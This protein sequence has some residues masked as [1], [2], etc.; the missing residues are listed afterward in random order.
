M[1]TSTF[2]RIKT[3]VG[4]V[5]SSLK[6]FDTKAQEGNHFGREGEYT[7]ESLKSDL[8]TILGDIRAL[9]KAHDEFVR[10]SSWEE[11]DT[12]A[13][14]L[15]DIESNLKISNYMGVVN[16]LDA[17]KVSIRS[18]NFRTSTESEEVLKERIEHLD[19]ESGKLEET[20]EE[21]E[22]IGVKA[23]AAQEHIQSAVE[24]HA[25]F[26][27]LF[28]NL[29]DKSSQIDTLLHQDQQRSQEINKLL[30]SAKSKEDAMNIF[31]DRIGDRENKLTEQE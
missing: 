31:S 3:R 5:E 28:N 4:E 23:Q 9:T 20:A 2:D 26:S 22:K 6:T 10:L 17:L 16:I 18:Y 24:Q 12:I 30:T 19:T 14:H 21:I 29:K 15:A 27:E 13:G 8:K 1:K 25:A 7:S 11:R